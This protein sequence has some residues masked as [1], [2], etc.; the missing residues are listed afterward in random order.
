[1]AQPNSASYNNTLK[2]M[3]NRSVKIPL[4]SAKDGDLV[5]VEL[6][7]EKYDV[8]VYNVC[9]VRKSRVKNVLAIGQY[10]FPLNSV[11]FGMKEGTEVVVLII[12]EQTAEAETV[13]GSVSLV[14]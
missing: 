10:D 14:D 8:P 1:M 3:F 11:E 7:H 6:P 13:E 12:Q 2:A 4:E 9:S 5:I